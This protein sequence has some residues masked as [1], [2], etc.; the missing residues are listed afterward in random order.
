VHTQFITPTHAHELRSVIA[1]V[2]E[3]L[4]FETR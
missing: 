1:K 3:T 4:R 2:L